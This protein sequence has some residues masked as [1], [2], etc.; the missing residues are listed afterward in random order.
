MPAFCGHRIRALRHQRNL[1][2]EQLAHSAGITLRHLWRLERNDR[3]NAWG[4]TV[5]RLALALGTTTDYL[6]GMSDMSALP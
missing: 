1:T 6:L 4:V 2:A 5:A 3:P